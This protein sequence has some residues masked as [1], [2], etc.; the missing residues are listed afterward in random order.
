M[1]EELKHLAAQ[2]LK[3]LR[4]KP[5]KIVSSEEALKD[6]TPIDWGDDVINGK[7]KVTVLPDTEDGEKMEDGVP[8]IAK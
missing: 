7:R 2:Y 3:V 5:I 8:W 4:S 6:V 1:S